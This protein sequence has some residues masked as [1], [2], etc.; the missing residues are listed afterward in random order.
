MR[1][2]ERIHIVLKMLARV[3]VVAGA[4]GLSPVRL[5]SGI[6]LPS[7]RGYEGWRLNKVSIREISSDGEYTRLDR[8]GGASAVNEASVGSIVETMLNA[9]RNEAY[10]LSHVSGVTMD[11]DSAGREIGMEVQIECGPRCYGSAIALEGNRALSEERFVRLTGLMVGDFLG[12]EKIRKGLE[13]VIAWYR[14]NGFPYAEVRIA[15][16]SI[17]ESGGVRLKIVFREDKH[18]RLGTISVDGNRVTREGVILRQF[19]LR[20]GDTF[21]LTEIERGRE[22]LILSDLYNRVD[23]VDLQKGDY[24][25]KVDLG[26]VVEEGSPNA[27]SGMAG[28]VPGPGGRMRLT[29]ML[30]LFLGNLWGTARQIDL[31]WMGRGEGNSQLDLRY[32]EPW[33]GSSPISGE[34]RFAQELRDTLFHRLEVAFVGSGPIDRGLEVRMGYQYQRIYSGR[35]DSNTDRGSNRQSLLLGISRS[36]PPSVETGRYWGVDLE[37]LIGRRRIYGTPY[38]EIEGTAQFSATLWR[39]RRHDLRLALGGKTIESRIRPTPAYHLFSVGGS[40]TVRGYA[41]DRIWGN[42]ACW[43]RVEFG[44][45]IS[46][47]SRYL[48]FYDLGIFDTVGDGRGGEFIQGYGVGAR[49]G[50]TL[51]A[52]AVDYAL[53]P[54]VG[55]LEG[56][57]HAGWVRDF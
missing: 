46:G 49:I 40:E 22:R 7:L 5:S 43:E 55:P 3:A 42:R 44:F 10:L 21:S 20:P 24:P 15:G 56:R 16:F 30:H 18:V 17:D 51:G 28:M 32:R 36:A 31:R 39:G 52:M 34:F 1:F 35:V 4:L 48:V 38:G 13:A 26:V 53:S 37:C 41:E 54:G 2:R 9:Y 23:E 14:D 19:G 47:D 45:G 57:I 6:E 29:G 50:S 27:L 12:E 25:Y 33:I 11:V 8:G